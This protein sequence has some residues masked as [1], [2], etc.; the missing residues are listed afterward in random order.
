MK[1]SLSRSSHRSGF[2]LIELLVVIAIIAVLA[3]VTMVAVSSALRAAK[4]AKANAT[5][6][7][8]QTAVLNYYTEYSVYPVPTGIGATDYFLDDTAGS[9]GAWGDLVC[10]LSGNINPYNGTAYV[11][12][13]P[14]TR[15]I[16]YLSM[17]N[18]D[19]DT[20]GAPKNPL[21]LG[22]GVAAYFN[23]AIDSDYDGILGAAPSA[24]AGKMPNFT[25]STSTAMD[26]SGTTTAGVAV[27]ANCNGTASSKNPSFW[28]HTY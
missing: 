1:P 9:K 6:N 16:A 27:W 22:G 23:I 18:S 15:A 12:T 25:K 8:I 21:S 19:V 13:V 28:V 10:A 4:Q 7:A 20:T 5:A 2:T 24:V 14:N 26:Y 11:G 3:G 17:K